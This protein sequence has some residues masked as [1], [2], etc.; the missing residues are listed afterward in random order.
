MLLRSSDVRNSFDRLGRYPKVI[1]AALLLRFSS[2]LVNSSRQ[3]NKMCRF[4]V[5]RGAII[6]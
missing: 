3:A 6:P 2:L 4:K 1:A 5:L